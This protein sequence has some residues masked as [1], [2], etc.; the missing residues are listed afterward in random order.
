M[1]QGRPIDS[2][3]KILTNKQEAFCQEYVT[4]GGKAN[5]AYEATYNVVKRNTAN[6]ASHELIHL[7]YIKERIQLLKQLYIDATQ[8]DPNQYITTSLL[9]VTEAT[10]YDYIDDEGELIEQSSLTP[11]QKRAIESLTINEKTDV[12]GNVLRTYKITLSNRIKA[13]DMLAKS[14]D[15][16][17]PHQQAKYKQGLTSTRTQNSRAAESSKNVINIQHNYHLQSTEELEALLESK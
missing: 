13:L 3:L 10:V 14:T 7:P 6:V 8:I 15:F 12:L 17:Q 5:E 1:A 9:A 2:P 4:N 11:A 16:Y